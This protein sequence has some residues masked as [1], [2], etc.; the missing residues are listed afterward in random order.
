MIFQ[1]ILLYLIYFTD[2]CGTSP[3][4]QYVPFYGRKVSHNEV[5][6]TLYNEGVDDC[7]FLCSYTKL[8]RV[9]EYH[10]QHRICRFFTKKA[11]GQTK[12]DRSFNTYYK[13]HCKSILALKHPE[14][15]TNCTYRLFPRRAVAERNVVIRMQGPLVSARVCKAHCNSAKRCLGFVYAGTRLKHGDCLLLRSTKPLVDTFTYDLY[16]K[17]H[18][19]IDEVIP[20]NQFAITTSHVHFTTETKA[21]QD[22]FTV[23]I[24][25][26]NTEDDKYRY[27]CLPA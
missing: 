17:K 5:L 20:M 1:I 19:V 8:C 24:S 26:N 16:V 27:I 10:I 9:I 2:L 4:S 18:C 3:C 25:G 6:K 15:K 21:P 11:I 12:Q 7:K 22:C 14:V 13:A 23:L